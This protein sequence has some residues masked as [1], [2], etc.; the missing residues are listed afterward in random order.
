LFLRSQ[1]VTVASGPGLR[2]PESS[3]EPSHPTWLPPGPGVRL[4][5]RSP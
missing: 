5:E 3:A 4:L 1:A 2:R